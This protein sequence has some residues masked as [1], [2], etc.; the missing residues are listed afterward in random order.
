MICRIWH[1]FS[2]EGRLADFIEKGSIEYYK[3]ISVGGKTIGND[4]MEQ[5]REREI[6]EIVGII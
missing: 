3:L 5:K 4:R 6:R 1:P 2:T